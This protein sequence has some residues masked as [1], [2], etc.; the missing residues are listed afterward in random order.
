MKRL[1]LWT[2]AWILVASE[3]AAAP[4]EDVRKKHEQML[5][6]VVRVTVED[7]GGSGTILYSEDRGDGCQTYVLTNNH[8]IEDAVRVEERWSS[9]LQR[10]VKQEVRE[11]VKVEVFRYAE[12]SVQDITDTCV[13]DIVARD[14]EEDLALLRLRTAHK[15]DY[16]ARLLPDEAEVH[17]FTPC[18]A[19]GCTLLHPPIATEG[20]I[21][22]M[23]EVIERKT[24][25]MS[26]AQICFGNSGGAIFIEHKGNYYFA[27]V[28]SRVQGLWLNPATTQPVTH[29]GWLVPIPR[30][31][32]WIVKERLTFLLDAKVKPSECFAERERIRVKSLKEL[33][34]EDE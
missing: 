1:L 29:M 31:K 32:E 27:G 5:Y 21:S 4:P 30:I 8:V 7:G 26:T 23:N 14:K 16:V 34:S 11:P 19:V 28:P 17:I 2:V 10:D 33:A 6:P 25:W 15:F 12:G 22:Y 20:T 3:V 24:Y 9:L 18:W 13:A